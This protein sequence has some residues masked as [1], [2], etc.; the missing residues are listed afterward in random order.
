MSQAEASGYDERAVKLLSRATI[1]AAIGLLRLSVCAVAALGL[2]ARLCHSGC[3]RLRELAERGVA[4]L[5]RLRAQIE[6][7]DTSR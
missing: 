7:P 3:L 6:A 5:H 4:A 2:L 1:A